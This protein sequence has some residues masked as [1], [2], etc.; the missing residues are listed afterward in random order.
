MHVFVFIA[1]W[2]PCASVSCSWAS[3]QGCL[4]AVMRPLCVHVTVCLCGFKQ[5]PKAGQK[6]G[7]PAGMELS[8]AKCLKGTMAVT[9]EGD[10]EGAGEAQP[11]NLL[12]SRPPSQSCP[13]VWGRR[14]LSAAAPAP[15]ER[16]SWEARGRP[17]T[18]TSRGSWPGHPSTLG[19]Q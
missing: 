17:L 18:W 8:T 12:A 19:A 9:W 11:L 2:H 5:E 14:S 6:P 4:W 7:L 3:G 16:V 1:L 15:E 10:Q 13:C